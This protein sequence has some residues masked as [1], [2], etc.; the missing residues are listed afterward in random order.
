[1]QLHLSLCLDE[2]GELLN[3]TGT[4]RNNPNTESAAA[5]VI[6]LPEVAPHPVYYPALDKVSEGPLPP[7]AQDLPCP[8]AVGLKMNFSDSASVTPESMVPTPCELPGA[9]GWVTIYIWGLS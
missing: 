7:G 1:M 4:V 9:G 8:E 3:P 2:K 5:L 6:S